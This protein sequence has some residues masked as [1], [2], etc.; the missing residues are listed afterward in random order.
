MGPPSPFK[1]EKPNQYSLAGPACRWVPLS[2]SSERQSGCFFRDSQSKDARDQ[3]LLPLSSLCAD[4]SLWRTRLKVV[5]DSAVRI[6]WTGNA[7]GD[8]WEILP[9][10][11]FFTKNIS[12]WILLHGFWISDNHLP[13]L[14]NGPGVRLGSVLAVGDIPFVF[15]PSG[16][17][18]WYL[19]LSLF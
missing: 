6:S 5:M 11:I 2:S 8:P 12:W 1:M 15:G 18:F 16:F 10:S 7:G 14:S 19:S 13:P 3:A 17:A 4:T 9:T